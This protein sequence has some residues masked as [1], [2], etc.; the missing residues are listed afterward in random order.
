MESNVEF[1]G[2]ECEE[3]SPSPSSS[4]VWP[5]DLAGGKRR[6]KRQRTFCSSQHFA[7]FFSGAPNVGHGIKGMDGPPIRSL[8]ALLSLPLFLSLFPSAE[9]LLP[10]PAEGQ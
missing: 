5:N 4:P 1:L 9:Q 10:S 3:I 8:P 2:E 7:F 6:G